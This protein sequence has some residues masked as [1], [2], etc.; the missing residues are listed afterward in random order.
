MDVRECAPSV[1][2]GNDSPCMDARQLGSF[3]GGKASCR[4]GP[5]A[6][7][8]KGN[9]CSR[10]RAAAVSTAERA[11]DAH[12][13]ATA[14]LAPERTLP[15]N[16]WPARSMSPTAPAGDESLTCRLVCLPFA[17]YVHLLPPPPPQHFT[18]PEG[19][20]RSGKPHAR[21][22]DSSRC[23]GQCGV[24]ASGDG[25]QLNPASRRPVR[26]RG[27]RLV[28]PSLSHLR[29]PGS[30]TTRSGARARPP[31]LCHGSPAPR[32]P[33]HRGTLRVEGTR[34]AL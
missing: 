26:P 16:V 9:R 27:P 13:S 2:I 4:A 18:V 12:P 30:Y 24:T 17:P 3:T 20:R 23:T 14:R 22:S 33:T 8:R 28:L 25:R 11:V 31:Q 7:G 21:Q 10:C 5:I 32:A 19:C 15:T 1:A 34:R 6:P 29:P